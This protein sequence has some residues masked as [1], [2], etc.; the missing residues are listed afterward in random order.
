MKNKI[1]NKSKIVNK[2]KIDRKKTKKIKCIR[3]SS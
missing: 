2:S 1:E 3:K